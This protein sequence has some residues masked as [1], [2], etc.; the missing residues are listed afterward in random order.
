MPPSAQAPP[1]ANPLRPQGGRT[2]RRG[3]PVGRVLHLLHARVPAPRRTSAS[4]PRPGAGAGA[5]EACAGGIRR[6]GAQQVAA[7]KLQYII[8]GFAEVVNR[9]FYRK[10]MTFP[11]RLMPE[12]QKMKY[13][14]RK[15]LLA[16]GISLSFTRCSP[17]PQRREHGTCIC[18][19]IPDSRQLPRAKPAPR[20]A[21]GQRAAGAL[22]R[23]GG[24]PGLRP[25]R[26][27]RSEIR[28]Q[29][30]VEAR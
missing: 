17:G 9:T 30:K 10:F 13:W 29:M 21:R 23:P 5:G 4:L 7:L 11:L 25:A 20:V 14:R 18:F 8:P 2:P 19:L 15:L 24:P 12:C 6:G 26:G 1:P 28:N 27:Q 3:G 22:R 16:G